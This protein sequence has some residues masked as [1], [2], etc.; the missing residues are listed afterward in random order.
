MNFFA[1][2]LKIKTI[3]R[4]CTE[5]NSPSFDELKEWYNGYIMEG[6]E[7]VYNPR[8]VVEAFSEGKCEDY[9]N[10]TGGYSE[11]EE[12]ITQNFD[13]LREA[14][15]QMLAG[16]EVEVNVLGFSN[17][18]NSFQDKD[19]ILTALIHLGY[20][21]CKN[22][23]ARIPNREIAEE[24]TNSVKRLSWG[25]VTR[26]LKQSR[27]LL[28]ATWKKDTDTVA[29]L[30]EE[31]HDDMQEFKEYN[32]EHT[33]KCV[34]H[35]AYYAAQDDYSLQ[36]EEPAGKGIADCLMIPRRKGIPGIIVE[37]KYDQSPEDAIE[38]IKQKQNVK[39][40]EHTAEKVLL[41]GINYCKKTKKHQCRI[42]ELM[43]HQ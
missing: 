15:I 7:P 28:E 6:Y 35:L 30:L 9:W 34:I 42:E 19:E 37:L 12:Y 10:K 3:S 13:G 17:D 29:A 39:K 27:K 18:L 33:L 26:L 8:S 25:T 38:Q 32:N 41:T 31:V 1:A 24:F 20:L 36:F 22:G 14:I 23:K 11:L 4:L 43:L 16:N 2:F 5:L 40:L 21:T